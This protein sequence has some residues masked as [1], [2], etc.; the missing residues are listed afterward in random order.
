MSKFLHY[1]D[2]GI[3][4]IVSLNIMRMHKKVI[5]MSEIVLFDSK[6]IK[7]EMFT[8]IPGTSD[9]REFPYQRPTLA[10]LSIW[11]I[12]LRKIS[13]EFHDL[14][15]PLREYIAPP[16]DFPCVGGIC[17]SAR[18]CPCFHDSVDWVRLAKS[19][20]WSNTFLLL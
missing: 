2:F 9:M 18:I 17:L 15:V 7:L 1:R 12:A 14:T 5:H 20:S 16:H 11:K 3:A 10:D 13:S 6:T 8:N 19:V 4:D